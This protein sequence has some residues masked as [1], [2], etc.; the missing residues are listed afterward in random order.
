[1]IKSPPHCHGFSRT[2]GRLFSRAGRVGSRLVPPRW[3]ILK[4]GTGHPVPWPVPSPS[5][6]DN[7]PAHDAPC[8]CVCVCVRVCV[9]VIVRARV[10]VCV[11]VCLCAQACMCVYKHIYHHCRFPQAGR[12][13]A[14]ATRTK[15]D[16]TLVQSQRPRLRVSVS[17]KRRCSRGP[18]AHCH[19]PGERVNAQNCLPPG[20]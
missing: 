7:P 10:C 14:A 1:M 13:P 18:A 20:R 19:S 15:A 9:C 4:L 8:V 17:T 16:R 11:C 5:R 2:K 12:L 6:P 3:V